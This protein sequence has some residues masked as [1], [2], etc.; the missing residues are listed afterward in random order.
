MTG[1]TTLETLKTITGI[2]ISLSPFEIASLKYQVWVR[3]NSEW[4]S[5]LIYVLR[6]HTLFEPAPVLNVCKNKK[7]SM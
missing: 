3:Q 5:L 4:T 2:G 7:N 1:S 6:M